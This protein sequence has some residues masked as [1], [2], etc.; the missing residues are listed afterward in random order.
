L[1]GSSYG[2]V[3]LQCLESIWIQVRFSF[4]RY[5]NR[6]WEQTNLGICD[7]SFEVAHNSLMMDLWKRLWNLGKTLGPKAEL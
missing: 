4:Q 7:G 2:F 1:G 6:V 5:S 3:G